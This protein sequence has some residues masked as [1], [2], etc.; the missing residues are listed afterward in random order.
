MKSLIVAFLV[1]SGGLFAVFGMNSDIPI[2]FA[3]QTLAEVAS[4]VDDLTWLGLAVVVSLSGFVSGLSGFGF[5]AVGA[6]T[7][8]LLPPVEAIPLLMAL[9]TANQLTSIHGLK[10]DLVPEKRT[11]C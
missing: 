11:P 4:S 8:W 7:L 9:S 1:A 6:L 2:F 10:S 5:S 3:Q